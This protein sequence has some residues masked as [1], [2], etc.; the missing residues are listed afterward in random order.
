MRFYFHT[1]LLSG[2]EQYFSTLHSLKVKL[3]GFV[4]PMWLG[5][6]GAVGTPTFPFQ[7]AVCPVQSCTETP[8]M[9]CPIPEEHSYQLPKSYMQNLHTH[10]AK[11]LSLAV[12]ASTLSRDRIKASR[13]SKSHLK[14]D[15][16]KNRKRQR[17][18]GDGEE[19]EKQQG[20][21]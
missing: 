10:R 7:P 3:K 11:W 21:F 8:K 9:S 2:T 20:P 14:G 1:K 18:G 15:R 12:L 6:L 16:Q 19:L 4:W 13:L 5:P 17:H